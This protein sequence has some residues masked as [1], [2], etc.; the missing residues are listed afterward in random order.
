MTRKL[1]SKLRSL[2]LFLQLDWYVSLQSLFHEF[3]SKTMSFCVLLGDL[4]FFCLWIFYRVRTLITYF[5]AFFLCVVANFH[6]SHICLPL[7]FE[8]GKSIWK[9]CGKNTQGTVSL[10]SKDWNIFW[11]SYSIQKLRRDIFPSNYDLLNSN[12]L[13]SQ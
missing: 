6:Y 4:Y 7:F 1:K 8:L 5:C 3:V 2:F 12:C 10:R 13:N 11:S 9:S